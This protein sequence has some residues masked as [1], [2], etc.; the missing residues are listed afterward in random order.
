MMKIKG[1]LIDVEKRQI[2]EVEFEN[3]LSSYYRLLKCDCVTTALYDEHHDVIVDDEG[4]LK[5]PIVGL[6]ETPDGGEYAGIF[7][8]TTGGSHGGAYSDYSFRIVSTIK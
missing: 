5:T 1:I 6:F 4:L 8:F 7:A 2:R 3:E